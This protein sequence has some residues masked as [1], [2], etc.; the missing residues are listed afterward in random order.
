[1][2]QIG[3]SSYALPLMCGAVNLDEAVDEFRA[4]MLGFIQEAI[5]DKPIS[6]W[7]SA[8]EQALK[9]S[10]KKAAPPRPSSLSETNS[11][12]GT[13]EKSSETAEPEGRLWRRRCAD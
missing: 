11:L 8:V 12:R 9:G 5:K 7:R 4:A 2:L 10:P 13:W 3:G 6:A 1:V